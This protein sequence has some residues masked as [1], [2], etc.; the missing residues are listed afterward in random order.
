MTAKRGQFRILRVGS[1]VHYLVAEG[2]SDRFRE[3]EQLE[4]TTKDFDRVRFFAQTHDSPIALD[5]LLK[6]LTIRA[7]LLPGWTA[8][9]VPPKRSP[10]WVAGVGVVVVAALAAGVRWAARRTRQA[11]EVG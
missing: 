2:E 3:I 5:L 9:P 8:S 11:Q 6:D 7:E 1:Q 10:W 4:F